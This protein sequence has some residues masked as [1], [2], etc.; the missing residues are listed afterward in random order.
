MVQLVRIVSDNETQADVTNY[1]NEAI[2]IK[3]DSKIALESLKIELSDIVTVTP[4]NDTFD[5]QI[6]SLLP[7]Y[8]VRI[9][10]GTYTESAFLDELTRSMN[11]SMDYI[12]RPRVGTLETNFTEWK[13]IINNNKLVIQYA[14]ALP[15]TGRLNNFKG[16]LITGEIIQTEEA[17]VNGFYLGDT[18]HK[19]S[20]DDTFSKIFTE[21][22]GVMSAL[23]W[24]ATINF[25]TIPDLLGPPVTDGIVIGLYDLDSGVLNVDAY[26]D[27][28]YCIVSSPGT[29]DD[30]VEFT[31]FVNGIEYGSIV[32][33]NPIVEGVRDDISIKITLQQNNVAFWIS[34]DDVNGTGEW[35]QIP[36]NEEFSTDYAHDTNFI[37]YIM[38]AEQYNTV[39]N[40]CF[41]PS[42]YQNA[43]SSGLTIVKLN[44]EIQDM[45]THIKNDS[46]GQPA[47]IPTTHTLIF[48]DD[49]KD[50]LGFQLNQYTVSSISNQF[51]AEKALDMGFYSDEIMVELPTQFVSAYEGSQHRRRNFIRFIPS[52]PLQLT[53]VRSHTFQYPL[54]M[55]LYNKD[56]QIMN[57][58]QVRLLDSNF[59]P[60]VISGEPASMTVLL[61]IE[62]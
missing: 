25:N 19:I 22:I 32:I 52:D 36:T 7:N 49:V 1:F 8:T 18:Y 44:S 45:E 39:Y 13:P 37:G 21:K 58:F 62:N 38:M 34:P 28:T 15:D 48:N 20:A 5:T 56:T 10:D 35:T 42:P 43:N 9:L 30:D 55:D 54:Y 51:L 47:Q 26:Q 29:T 17:A 60:L 6:S 40:V 31:A 59:K 3:K 24:R 27:L 16:D 61:I 12:F 11:G 4:E 33:N 46:L 41:T 50:L 53:K 14:T 2:T 57:Y 23:E